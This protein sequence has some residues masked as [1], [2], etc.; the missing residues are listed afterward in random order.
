MPKLRTLPTLVNA[1]R[2]PRRQP[3]QTRGVYITMTASDV[4]GDSDE[5]SETDGEGDRE[6]DKAD[7]A[8][9]GGLQGQQ[10]E[11]LSVAMVPLKAI[12]RANQAGYGALV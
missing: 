3:T 12:G 5:E 10:E 11:G 4:D 1:M 2:E 8:G 6:E 9:G 7:G